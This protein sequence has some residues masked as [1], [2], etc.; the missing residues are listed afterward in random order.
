MLADRIA[1]EVAVKVADRLRAHFGGEKI[2]FSIAE[3]AERMGLSKSTLKKMIR[4]HEIACVRQGSRVL[5][6][7]KA[8]EEWAER[9]RV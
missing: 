4:D 9:Q 8:I 3:A 7:R 5:I 2:L 6:H 1:D